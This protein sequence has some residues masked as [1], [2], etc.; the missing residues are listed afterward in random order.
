MAGVELADATGVPVP[1]ELRRRAVVHP[2]PTEQLV[3]QWLATG[4]A[5]LASADLTVN[6]ADRPD[7]DLQRR[8]WDEDPDLDLDELGDWVPEW[9]SRLSRKQLLDMEA[10]EAWRGLRALGHR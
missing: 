8:R 2:P 1:E 3:H 9:A 6:P 4:R 7:P 10:A 5:P